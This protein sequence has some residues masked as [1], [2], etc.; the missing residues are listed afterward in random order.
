M[1]DT[2]CFWRPEGGRQS[3][4]AIYQPYRSIAGDARPA[5]TT[6]KGWQN[7]KNSRHAIWLCETLRLCASVVDLPFDAETRLQV[8][9][10]SGDLRFTIYDLR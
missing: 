1:R 6:L 3:S 7:K 9:T 10:L 4:R 2:V 5:L 8:D